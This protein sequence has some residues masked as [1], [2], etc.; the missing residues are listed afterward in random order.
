MPQN[1][2]EYFVGLMEKADTWIFRWKSR[3]VDFSL[4]KPTRRFSVEKADTSNLAETA[5]T[6]IIVEKGHTSDVSLNYYYLS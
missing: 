6:S 3:H 1:R 4:E 2:Q 5:D